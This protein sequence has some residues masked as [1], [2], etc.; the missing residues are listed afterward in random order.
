MHKLPLFILI[1]VLA[2][3]LNSCCKEEELE[4]ALLFEKK[5]NQIVGKWELNETAIYL[6]ADGTKTETSN[7]EITFRE[8]GT[9]TAYLWRIVE[10]NT[11]WLYQLNPEVVVL[12]INNS[13]DTSFS[14]A[15]QSG[16][17]IDVLLNQPNKQKWSYSE[18]NTFVDYPNTIEVNYT[19]EMDRIE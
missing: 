15:S 6:Y 5:R 16:K 10:V 8:D 9:G 18:Y 7:T 11:Q 19:W 17:F 4:D 3:S 14:V 2:A 1:T 12:Q 13:V